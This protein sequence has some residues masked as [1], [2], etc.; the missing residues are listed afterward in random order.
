MFVDFNEINKE[1]ERLVQLERQ[2]K[3][4]ERREAEELKKLENK[5]CFM[6][7]RAFIQRFPNFFNSNSNTDI[8]ITDEN[9]I[10]CFLDK[11]E[12]MLEMEAS[13]LQDIQ[14]QDELEHRIEFD[15]G[16]ELGN[17][18]MTQD[19]DTGLITLKTFEPRERQQVV[20]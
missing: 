16:I 6:I 12:A 13:V 11:I 4:K 18:V 3:A 5:R 10:K 15:L 14:E 9:R 2:A 8:K 20:L 1:K 7:G 19:K 17:Y